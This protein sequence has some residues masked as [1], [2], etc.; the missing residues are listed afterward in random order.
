MLDRQT[1]ELNN[2]VTKVKM[3]HINNLAFTLAEVLITLGIIGIIAALTIPTLIQ[4]ANEKATV[5]AVKKAY[6]VLSQAYTLAVQENGTPDTWNLSAD[7]NG[8]TNILNMLAPYLKISQN[9]GTGTGCFPANAYQ[10]L[11]GGDY[12]GGSNDTNT[13]YAKAKL[14]DGTLLLAASFADCNLSIGTTPGLQS[15]CGGISVD[16]NGFKKP[17]Q[18]GIDYFGFYITK[19]GIIPYGSPSVTTGVYTFES[20]CQDRS[21]GQGFMCT[22]WVVYNENMGYLHCNNL[23]WAGPTKCN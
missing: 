1:D 15:I 2:L 9:C 17:N 6:S 21:T 18:F 5:T 10:Q 19:F 7:G 8:A 20:S 23:S 16:V 4:N 14:S 3:P 13:N 12:S 22:A 11:K